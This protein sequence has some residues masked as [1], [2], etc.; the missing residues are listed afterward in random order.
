MIVLLHGYWDLVTPPRSLEFWIWQSMTFMGR[1]QAAKG[2]SVRLAAGV[3]R[4]ARADT[5]LSSQSRVTLCAVSHLFILTAQNRRCAH[6]LMSAWPRTRPRHSRHSTS[7]HV[8]T[9]TVGITPLQMQHCIP[10][11]PVSTPLI[12]MPRGP[13]QPDTQEWCAAHHSPGHPTTWGSTKWGGGPNS[14]RHPRSASAASSLPWVACPQAAPRYAV[15]H[16]Q[17][18][19]AVPVP[20]RLRCARLVHR[21][22]AL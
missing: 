21:R 1:L 3:S 22:Q 7:T 16:C 19:T 17:T 20:P 12:P 14:A 2:H 11:P 5:G 4:W 9:A 15:L 8:H 6:T 10:T 13:M 18:C